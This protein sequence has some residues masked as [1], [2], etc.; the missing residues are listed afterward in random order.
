MKGR[1]I[2]RRLVAGRTGRR[3]SLARAA[4][5][6]PA[7]RAAQCL[8]AQCLV[9]QC[10]EAQ[11]L[12]AQFLQAQGLMAQG[13]DAAGYAASTSPRSGLLACLIRTRYG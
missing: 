13:L 8:V 6:K 1:V 9:A 12:E 5:R 4:G 11:C 2:R 10:L 7:R 3:C